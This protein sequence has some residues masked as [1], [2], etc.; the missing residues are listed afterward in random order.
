MTQLTHSCSGESISALDPWQLLKFYKSVA[1]FLSL[2]N[3]IDQI[4]SM[5][6]DKSWRCLIHAICYSEK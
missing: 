4:C 5:G 6:V 2:S 3:P 1:S